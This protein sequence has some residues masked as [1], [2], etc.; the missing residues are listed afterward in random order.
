MM[1]RRTG[2]ETLGIAALMV[3]AAA[4][5]S[6]A[7]SPE[8]AL[9]TPSMKA[10]AVPA[11][12]HDGDDHADHHSDH[13]SS[14]AGHAAKERHYLMEILGT[15]FGGFGKVLKGEVAGPENM[16]RYTRIMVKAA[17]LSPHPFAVDTRGT[18]IKTETLDAAWENW[19]DFSA[20]LDEMI[21]DV[22]ALDAAV[23]TGEK[24]AIALAAR[25][26]G[27]NCKSCHEK[28]K[29]ED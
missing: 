21:A 4:M 3:V 6:S 20:R 11:A 17:K 22:E 15:A 25:A 14:H 13:D 5:P 9:P 7:L 8:P 16:K 1:T 28:Y 12:P 23:K 24:R 10:P 2:F 26:A 29:A 18:D 27:K 19:D